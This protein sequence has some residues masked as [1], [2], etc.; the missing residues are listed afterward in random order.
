MGQLLTKPAS[1]D[2]RARVNAFVCTYHVTLLHVSHRGGVAFVDLDFLKLVV[3]PGGTVIIRDE[4]MQES[5][6][7]V[8]QKNTMFLLAC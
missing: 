5:S 4:Y 1:P 2:V 6:L 7:D 3:G 8:W